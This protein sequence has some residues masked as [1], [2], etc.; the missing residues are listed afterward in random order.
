MMT[1][2]SA[3]PAF[4]SPL[5][6]LMCFS[7]L[8]SP[9][10]SCTSGAPDGAFQYVGRRPL[11]SSGDFAIVTEL[12]DFQAVVPAEGEGAEIVVAMT[13]RIVR[14]S[15]VRIVASRRF[16][17]RAVAP[18]LDDADLVIIDKRRARANQSEVMNIIG[19]VKNKNCILIEDIVDTAGTLCSGAGALKEHGAKRVVAYC[20]H[21]VLSGPAVDNIMNS[22]MDE[23]VVTDTIPLSDAAVACGKIR[24]LSIAQML[25]ETI[26][27]MAHG[28][29]V[30]S[31]Y[32]D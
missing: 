8:L 26:R 20:V 24:Q 6:T 4:M 1:S 19:E 21:P 5:S 2:A 15:D 13:S 29:S 23:L 27:R 7:R 3:K 9:R 11:G 16:D 22:E 28:E 18:S 14:E 30:S 32:V 25:A 10:S 31:M 17:A 12:T